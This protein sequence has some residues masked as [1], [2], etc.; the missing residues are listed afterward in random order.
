[1][2]NMQERE[3]KDSLPSYFRKVKSKC[4]DFHMLDPS[5]GIFFSSCLEPKSTNTFPLVLAEIL[6]S[7]TG[8]CYY[9]NTAEIYRCVDLYTA[10]IIWKKLVIHT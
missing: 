10:T 8:W 1:M 6:C 4:F 2:A 7:F 3:M 9:T 5:R